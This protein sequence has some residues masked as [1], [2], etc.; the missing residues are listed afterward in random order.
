MIVVV[1][2]KTKKIKIGIFGCRHD[3]NIGNYLIKFAMYIKLSELGYDPYIVTTNQK[4]VNISFI[5]RTT[6]NIIV[7]NYSDIK[8]N[9]YDILIV[10][11]DQTWRRWDKYFY[12]YGFLKFAKNWNKLKFVYGA[13][14]GFDYWKFNKKEE[15]II[16]PLIKNFSEISVREKG[17]IKLIKEHFGISP[18]LV[19]DPTLIIDKK[20]YLN[21]I[22]NYKSRINGN[23][24]YI[25]VYNV[26]KISTELKSFLEKAEKKL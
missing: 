15:N 21:L 17:S 14:L 10:N 4:K 26:Y 6:N 13:S 11:S 3:I 7:Q 16:E 24:N 19:L 2:F 9:D 22:K 8:E 5:N 12:D 23:I 1:K 18:K 20:Y 25:F